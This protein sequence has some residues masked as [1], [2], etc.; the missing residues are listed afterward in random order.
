[1]NYIFQPTRATSS[2]AHTIKVAHKIDET[3]EKALLGGGKKRVDAQHARVRHF[4]K[5]KN[6]LI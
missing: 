6:L 2:I 4:S 3:R 5:K 1:M